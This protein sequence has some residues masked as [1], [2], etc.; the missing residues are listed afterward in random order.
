MAQIA[1]VCLP[2]KWQ[3]EGFQPMVCG[4]AE[5]GWEVGTRSRYIDGDSG[6]EMKFFGGK[7]RGESVKPGSN[8]SDVPFL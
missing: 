5:S 4:T 3:R 1:T 6:Q 8:L 7:K 2:E